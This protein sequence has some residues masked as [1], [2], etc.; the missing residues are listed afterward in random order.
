MILGDYLAY[1]G[2][3][4]KS[5]VA[6]RAV[7]RAK[8]QQTQQTASRLNEMM[9]S[10]DPEDM[11][12]LGL[13][14]ARGIGVDADSAEATTWF[15]K[16]AEAGHPMA[17]YELA[18]RYWRGDGIMQD[19]ASSAVWAK[20]A[21]EGGVTDAAQIY[22]TMLLRGVGVPMD[23]D[24]AAKWLKIAAGK[25]NQRARQLLTEMGETQ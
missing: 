23:R 3:M 24:G 1:I 21:A 19:K 25:G 5:G 4:Q 15:G 20:K 18:R 12:Q 7:E 6:L 9:A 11:F 10:D 16:A 17:Q 13:I 2:A 22:G 8:A 14:Y